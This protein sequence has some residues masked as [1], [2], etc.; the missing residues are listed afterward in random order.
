[1]PQGA[2]P[3]K[4]EEERKPAGM[5]ALAG[6][7]LYLDLACALRIP[8]SIDRHLSFRPSQGWTDSQMVLSL[9]LLAIAGG[10]C[11]DD[12]KVLEADEGFRRILEHVEPKSPSSRWRAGKLRPSLHPLRS[13]GT[14]LPFIRTMSLSGAARLFLVCR[15]LAASPG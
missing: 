4:Y 12:L 1:M 8:K 11:V 6:L 14:F 2:L 13:S 7:P 15:H 3:Y 10:D 9:M 5:T